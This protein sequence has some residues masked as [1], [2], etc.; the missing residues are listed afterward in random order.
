MLR[1]FFKVLTCLLR[2]PALTINVYPIAQLLCGPI[3]C[4]VLA[5]RALDLVAL[6]FQ[7]Q[8]GW[9]AQRLLKPDH[10]PP[11]AVEAVCWSTERMMTLSQA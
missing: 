4:A 6:R 11:G 10:G 8:G 3:G 9:G 2:P 7:G 1:P 5:A